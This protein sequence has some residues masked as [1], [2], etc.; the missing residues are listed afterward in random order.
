[1]NKSNI[2]TAIEQFANELSISSFD[3]SAIVQMLECATIDV[4]KTIKIQKNITY[5]TDETDD[6]IQFLL[7]L[8]DKRLKNSALSKWNDKL[9]NEKIEFV[10]TID[11]SAPYD[12]NHIIVAR[13]EIK[14]KRNIEDFRNELFNI[15][16]EWCEL[17]D[18]S[19]SG[20]IVEL[21]ANK[22]RYVYK[23]NNNNKQSSTLS[24][25]KNDLIHKRYE[26]SKF[27]SLRWFIG[28]NILNNIDCE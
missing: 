18:V 11:Q 6:E 5:S 4:H 7:N 14:V 17:T 27:V 15:Y 26:S 20:N 23:F 16:K 22:R 21:T 3:K 9:D 25:V 1:M 10:K 12:D 24:D 8:L 19:T 13:T 2:E 28:K